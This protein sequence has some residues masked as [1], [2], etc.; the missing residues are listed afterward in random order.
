MMFYGFLC[1][2]RLSRQEEDVDICAP[3]DAPAHC[4]PSDNSIT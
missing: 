3:S 1:F 2:S 4:F